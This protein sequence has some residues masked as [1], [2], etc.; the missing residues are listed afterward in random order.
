MFLNINSLDHR[1]FEFLFDFSSNSDFIGQLMITVTNLSSK[2]FAGIYVLFFIYLFINKKDKIIPYIIAPATSFAL[3]HIIR[4]LYV[5]PRPFVA[6]EIESLIYHDPSGSLPSM[7]AVSAFAIAMAIYLINKKFG[8]FM[9]LLAFLTGLSRVMVGVHFPMD[10]VIGALIS[11][12]IN[13]II[14]NLYNHFFGTRKKSSNY[15]RL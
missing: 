7:H 3:V 12:S 15:F 6:L 9:L 11:V 2:I 14:F 10:I 4:L 5:R 13:L 1:I 8:A